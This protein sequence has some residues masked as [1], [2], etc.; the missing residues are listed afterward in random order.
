MCNLEIILASFFKQNPALY[1]PGL[2][3]LWNPFHA[4]PLEHDLLILGLL[5]QGGSQ[6]QYRIETV[7]SLDN[8][9]QLLEETPWPDLE[10]NATADTSPGCHT[11]VFR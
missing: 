7:D 3:A 6:V 9:F 4:R 1:H 2:A 5:Q 8:L 10:Q 11:R